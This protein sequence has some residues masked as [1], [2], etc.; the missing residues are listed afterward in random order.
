MPERILCGRH[1]SN[2]QTN[3]F[4]VDSHTSRVARSR[5]LWLAGCSVAKSVPCDGNTYNPK[6]NQNNAG[7]C[8]KCP[9]NSESRR[10]STSWEDCVCQGASP[11]NPAGSYWDP[12]GQIMDLDLDLEFKV[13]PGVWEVCKSCPVG[14]DCSQAG[15]TLERLPVKPGYFRISNMTTDI[16]LCLDND[17]G[18]NASSVCK[19]SNGGLCGEAQCADL[20]HNTT[21]GPYCTLCK[22]EGVYRKEDRCVACEGNFATTLAVGSAST[23][24][25]EGC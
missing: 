12:L 25:R 2:R 22:E 11:T 4:G 1:Q 14:S 23:I 15:S 13:L 7:A 16:R 18:T 10:A 20:C 6:T 24:G 19:S 9:A 17:G 5:T 21:A 3:S 8:L